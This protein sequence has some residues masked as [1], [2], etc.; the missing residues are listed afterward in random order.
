LLAIRVGDAIFE[1]EEDGILDVF[2][3]FFIGIAL[4]IT[5]LQLWAGGK[6]A[7]FVLFEQDGK[8]KSVHR[9]CGDRM[10]IILRFF[11]HLTLAGVSVT[12][13]DLIFFL[14]ISGLSACHGRDLAM[15]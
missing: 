7:I 10:V 2:Q 5:S 11:G 13:A 6:V 14:G 8:K 9:F 1:V 12:L 15:T 4:G 3:R